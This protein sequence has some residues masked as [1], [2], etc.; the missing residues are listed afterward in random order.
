MSQEELRA[1]VLA[2]VQERAATELRKRADHADTERIAI[3]ALE[4]GKAMFENLTHVQL[5][6][7]EIEKERRVLALALHLACEAG[8]STGDRWIAEARRRIGL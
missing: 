4:A 5:R 7:S 6:C 3:A 8:V 1:S 2:C